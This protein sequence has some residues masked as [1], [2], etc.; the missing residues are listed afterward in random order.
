MDKT[1]ISA[2]VIAVMICLLVTAGCTS[3]SGTPVPG[4][5]GYVTSQPVT[6]VVRAPQ[7]VSF[8]ATPV[9]YA[10]VNGVTLGYF[11]NSVQVNHS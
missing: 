11:G 7:A 4:T 5:P 8:N 9:Q 6:P 2:L 1:H 3:T 10:K